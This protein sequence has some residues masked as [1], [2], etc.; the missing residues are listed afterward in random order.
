MNNVVD[1]P[2]SNNQFSLTLVPTTLTSARTVNGKELRMPLKTLIDHGASHSIVNKRCL[3][4][5]TPMTPSK[6]LSFTTTG[7]TF[8]TTSFVLLEDFRMPE[9]NRNR[10]VAKVK[11][12]VF[13]NATV[14]YDL[15][16]GRDFLNAAG[17]DAKSSTLACE[18]CGDSIPFKPPSFLGND[19]AHLAFK[20][21]LSEPPCGTE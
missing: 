2:T 5:G 8:K 19:G 12:S 11:A 20:R 4:K 14:K 13:D 16:L 9:F 21:S 18:W 6:D 1:E 7:G 15:I 10:S 17:V 3:P